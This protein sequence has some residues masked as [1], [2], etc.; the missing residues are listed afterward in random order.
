MKTLKIMAVFLAL[1]LLSASIREWSSLD[2]M[3]GPNRRWIWLRSR[4][5]TAEPQHY[6]FVFV[7]SSKTLNGVKPEKLAE[8]IPGSRSLNVAHFKHGHDADYY[9]VERL[10]ARHDVDRLVVEIPYFVATE[11]HDVTQHLVGMDE[12]LGELRAVV[13][14]LSLVDWLTYSEALR[15]RIERVSSYLARLAFSLPTHALVWTKSQITGVPYDQA[16]VNRGWDWTGGF[17]FNDKSLEQKEGFAEYWAK[18]WHPPTRLQA[19][20]PRPGVLDHPEP[21]SRQDFYLKH[22]VALAK[23]HGTQLTFVQIP[24]LWRPAPSIDRYAYYRAHGDVLIPDLRL[25]YRIEYYADSH[26]FFQDGTDIFTSHLARLLLEG[27]QI[28]PYHQ[29]YKSVEASRVGR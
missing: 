26:H 6:D 9:A 22:L 21:G 15:E 28:S 3:R 1:S 18:N 14:E 5:V 17:D 2:Q 7:G 19:G 20:E 4:A 27:P 25:L 16:G 24:G 10:L 12:L 29:I 8:E 23:F 11:P 13:L